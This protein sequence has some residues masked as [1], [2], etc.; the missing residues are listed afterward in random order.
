MYIVIH[1]LQNVLCF[2]FLREIMNEW[3]YKYEKE[4]R[5]FKGNILNRNNIIEFQLPHN[6]V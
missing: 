5:I 4:A 1:C 2:K 6:F 3:I